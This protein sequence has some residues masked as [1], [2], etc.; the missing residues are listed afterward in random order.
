MSHYDYDL[1]VIGAGSGG[2][3]ASRMSAALGARVAVA[4]DRFLGGT[5]VN[6]GC[7]PKKLMVYASHFREDFEDARGFGWTVGEGRFDWPTLIANKDVE[8]RRLNGVYERMLKN[9]GVT[10]VEGRA[11]VVGPHEVEVAGRRISARHILVATGGKPRRTDE[12]VG[13][14]H[15][16][17][18]DDLFHLDRQPERVLIAGGGYIAVE[19]AGIFNGLGSEV[20]QLYRDSLFLRGFDEDLRLFLAEEMP[21][22]GIDLRFKTVIR[23]VEKRGGRYHVAMSDDTTG[24]Y[25]AVVLAIGRDPNTAGLGL[26]EAGVEL[27]ARGAVKVDEHYRSSV[28]SILA[29]GDVTDRVQLT[30]VALAEGMVVARDLFGGRQT[31]LDY[32][33]IPSAV[34]SQ[35]PLATVGLTEVDARLHHG[36]IDVYRTSFRPMK[37]T[38]SG[39]DERTMM[40]LVVERASQKVIGVHMGGMDAAEIVQGIAIAVKAG[41]TKQVFDATIGIHPTA[42]EEFVTMREKLPEPRRQ[43]AE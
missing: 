19:F 27:T 31:R 1:F 11:R 28:P 4:E 25:D 40:K 34:F 36:E 20:T 30:P 38:L 21:K 43:A 5:C 10:I 33:N 16:V 2:V 26:E 12:F 39:R 6:I 24:E 15:C 3:R 9:A 37:H 22:K 14:E 7:V 17:V 8:I 41:A 13:H 29:I 18:S 35:P 23:A 32:D 42:A